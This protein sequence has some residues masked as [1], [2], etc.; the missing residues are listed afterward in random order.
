MGRKKGELYPSNIAFLVVVQDSD[1]TDN[2]ISTILNPSLY[3]VSEYNLL[4]SY[5]CKTYDIQHMLLESGLQGFISPLHKPEG[6]DIQFHFH[7]MLCRPLNHGLSFHTWR[8]IVFALGGLNGYI[9][10]LDAPHEYS[11]YLIHKGYPDKIQ[12]QAKDVISVNLDYNVFSSQS[13]K[14]IS[15]D[16]DEF[17]IFQ[18]IIAFLNSHGLDLFCSLVDYCLLEKPQWLPVVKANR[19]LIIDYMR[20][21]EYEYKR[22][23][24]QQNIKP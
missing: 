9:K 12:Y 1:K 21:R 11:R 5:E 19:S 22:Y 17:N 23:I 10:I 18:D 6:D 4:R 13:D 16:L 8:S 14:Q 7:V 15:L 24:R 20:S 3:S 2:T